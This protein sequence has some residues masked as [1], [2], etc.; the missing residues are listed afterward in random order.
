MKKHKDL[1]EEEFTHLNV[2]PVEG[3]FPHDQQ[4]SLRVRRAQS[5]LTE[6]QEAPRAG[7]VE[8]RRDPV[9]HS[10]GLFVE[11][12]S[13]RREVRRLHD[14]R[15]V[16]RYVQPVLPARIIYMLNKERDARLP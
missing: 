9:G 2:V 1:Y 7:Q 8:Q 11:E 3:A 16:F 12:H 4:V 13:P 15:W 14:L 10:V 6:S 5:L